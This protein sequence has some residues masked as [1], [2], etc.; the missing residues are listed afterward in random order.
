MSTAMNESDADNARREELDYRRTLVT[1][2]STISN[3][4]G[5]MALL[6]P[7]QS[8]GQK[9]LVEAVTNLGRTY[10]S[11]ARA[12]SVRIHLRVQELYDAQRRIQEEEE[13]QQEAHNDED[14]S[15]ETVL[16]AKRAAY[17]RAY[18]GR[19]R[20][21]IPPTGMGRPSV[22]P[23]SPRELDHPST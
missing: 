3:Q 16:E 14:E 4:L 1:G 8:S 5:L 23:V 18:G 13:R 7:A 15:I 11:M 19:S 10:E 22:P 12:T 20:Q 9:T 2:L 17:Q 21:P 6:M